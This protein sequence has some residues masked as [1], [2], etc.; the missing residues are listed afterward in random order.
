MKRLEALLIAL[1][2][3]AVFLAILILGSTALLALS[4]RWLILYRFQGGPADG[5]WPSS[6]VADAAGHL[7]GTTFQGGNGPVANCYQ[8]LSFGCGTVFEMIPPSPGGSWS[9]VVLYSFQGETD[10]GAPSYGL[11]LDKSGNLYGTT[12]STIFEL[13][14]PASPGGAWTETTLYTFGS[15][16]LGPMGNL[17]FDKAGNL[18]G[19]TYLQPGGTVYEL[20]PPPTPG[21]SWT[22][23]IIYYFTGGKDG[24]GPQS[25]V[26]M[27]NA[28]ALYGTTSYGGRFLCNMGSGC[29]TVFKL[30][31]PA[32]QGGV[33]TE[34]TL[35]GFGAQNDGKDPDDS[36]VF[37]AAGNLY[38]TTPDGGLYQCPWNTY[39][40]TVF[41]LTPPASGEGPWTETILHNFT[42]GNDGSFPP[43]NLTFDTQGTLYGVTS[44]GGGAFAG[45]HCGDWGCGTVF[46]L[47]PPA[48]AGSAWTEQILHRFGSQSDDGLAPVAGLLR[49]GRVFY[50]TTEAGGGVNPH[51]GGTCGTVF[52]F[53]E[54]P[55]QTGGNVTGP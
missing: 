9:E 11:T 7:Y 14:P 55:P 50:G 44:E 53:T 52:T 33:W 48:T 30:T 3:T 20:S 21:A 8:R 23:T 34:H 25:G 45:G 42:G 6:L 26:I 10:G 35:Y 41:E 18:Y 43:S 49:I 39:C 2:P 24:G 40:G 32:T 29:G 27:D 5:Y 51:C 13:S 16:A 28:G 22:F 46:R 38:G 36:L 19:T 15:N 31:P 54:G 1:R 17:I 47:L 37:D 12:S 4:N